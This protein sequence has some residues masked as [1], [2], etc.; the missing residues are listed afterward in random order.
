MLDLYF[1]N[2]QVSSYSYLSNIDTQYQTIIVDDYNMKSNI[3]NK[4]TMQTQ[5]VYETQL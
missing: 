4:V 3:K 5:K 2:V 1:T